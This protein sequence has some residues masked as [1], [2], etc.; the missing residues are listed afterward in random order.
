VAPLVADREAMRA[1]LGS[2]PLT[3]ALVP[4]GEAGRVS[5]DDGWLELFARDDVTLAARDDLVRVSPDGLQWA[6]DSVTGLDVLVVPDEYDAGPPALWGIEG[7]TADAPDLHTVVAPLGGG[8]VS[9][10]LAAQVQAVVDALGS[11]V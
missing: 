9:F 1:R 5:L 2:S 7:L 3:T 10:D 11:R 6:D 8:T 4:D